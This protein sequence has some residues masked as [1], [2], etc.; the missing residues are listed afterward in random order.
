VRRKQLP[1]ALFAPE[2][3]GFHLG[4]NVWAQ[5]FLQLAFWQHFSAEG[6]L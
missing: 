1:S 6:N 4:E 3:V 5:F 2:V